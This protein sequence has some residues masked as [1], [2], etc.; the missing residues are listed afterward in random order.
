MSIISGLYGEK[1]KI[2]EQ[3]LLE[4]RTN[5]FTSN[6]LEIDGGV[7]AHE[8]MTRLVDA[9]KLNKHIKKFILMEIESIN[10]K[11]LKLLTSLTNLEEIIAMD[12]CVTDAVARELLRSKVKA[13]YLDANSLTD[14]CLEGIENNKTLITLKLCGNR[15]TRRGIEI[16]AKNETIKELFLSQCG[17]LDDI[18]VTYL[19]RMQSLEK[20]DLSNNNTTDVGFKVL[21]DSNIKEVN[22]SGNWN[23]N[24][25][26]KITPE[27]LQLRE[28]A[29]RS[30]P[31]PA[32]EI[33]KK[34]EKPE[35]KDQAEKKETE[36]VEASSKRLKTFTGT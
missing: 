13:L 22:L 5:A 9:I 18:C 6:E 32:F 35:R 29:K 2:S 25:I 4:I 17:G 28:R 1:M 12:A 21:Y 30:S 24:R 23:E 11:S 14:A 19:A 36:Q 10:E 3:L 34:R 8:D 26:K 31:T 16:L 15:F 7:I 33:S 20:L 27:R